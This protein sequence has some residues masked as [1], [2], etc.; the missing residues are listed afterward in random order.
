MK[1]Q[2]LATGSLCAKRCLRDSLS[3]GTLLLLVIK[4]RFESSREIW[5]ELHVRRQF[6]LFLQG[7]HQE[8]KPS[9][10]YNPRKILLIQTWL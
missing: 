8:W 10:K 9:Y 1:T 7:H 6:S 4:A 3:P 5:I 2:K